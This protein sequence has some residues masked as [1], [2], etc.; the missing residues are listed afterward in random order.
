MP[1]TLE[2]SHERRQEWISRVRAL[3]EQIVEWS[4]GAGWRVEREEKTVQ[5][6]L[7]GRYDVPVLHIHLPGGELVLNPIGLDVIGANGRVDLEAF[8][9]L[10]RVKL[11]GSPE[12]WR[13]M[14]DSNV[15]L[16][17]PWNG[18]TFVQLADDLMS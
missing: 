10:A 14:T 13:I 8:P 18:H 12:G 11:I 3:A 17:Q 6:E 5:E 1:Q 16:R 4:T 7:L 9:T 15:P 2:Q